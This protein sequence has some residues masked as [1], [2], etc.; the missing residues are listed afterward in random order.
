MRKKGFWLAVVIL[1]CF[2]TG[3]ICS[4]GQPLEA[5]QGPIEDLLKILRKPKTDDTAEK[6][7]RRDA[8]WSLVNNAFDFQGMAQ[9]ALGKHRRSFPDSLL[10]Q[11]VEE[12]TD[13]VG[14]N[15]FDR[16]QSEYNDEKVVFLGEEMLSP[17][18]ALVQTIIE[19]PNGGVAV[20]YKLRLKGNRWVVYDVVI[21]KTSLIQNYRNEIDRILFKESPDKL[22]SILREKIEQNRSQGEKS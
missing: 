20:D 19:R 8:M 16:I 3:S 12:F 1:I 14:T 10:K 11:Y 18:K 4:A 6:N 17:K 21:E 22:I 7:S 13:L 15:Y 9:L 5:I 2:A